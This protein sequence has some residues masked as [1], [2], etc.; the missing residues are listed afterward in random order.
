MHVEVPAVETLSMLAPANAEPSATVAARVAG[1]R[2]RQR[3]RFAAMGIAARTNSEV[4][5]DALQQV[6]QFDAAAQ[7]LLEDATK[8]LNLSMRGLTRVMRVARTIADL[9]GSDAVGHTHLAEALSYRQQP[10]GR[11]LEAA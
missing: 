2:D 7:K 6:V 9:A 4:G 1:A 8:Q 10:Q 5:G 11:W 3:Q